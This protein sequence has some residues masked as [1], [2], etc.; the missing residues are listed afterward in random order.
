MCEYN[1]LKSVLLAKQQSPNP[2]QINVKLSEVISSVAFT[3]SL[4][5][6]PVLR[7]H[8]HVTRQLSSSFFASIPLHY[9]ILLRSLFFLTLPSQ[10]I[11]KFCLSHKRRKNR[12]K[13]ALFFSLFCFHGRNGNTRMDCTHW[14]TH[15]FQTSYLLSIVTKLI[16]AVHI[17]YIILHSKTLS[18][19]AVNT[20][21]KCVE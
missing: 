20:L 3:K 14:S 16:I 1:R 11:L 2:S 19:Y 12:S 4:G 21:Y 10:S 18:L 17:A 7:G 13:S 5:R 9:I 6:R 8:W 15:G